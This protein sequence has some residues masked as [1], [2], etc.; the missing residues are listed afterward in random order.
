MAKYGFDLYP[1]VDPAKNKIWINY[2]RTQV[3]I[4]K[5]G[6][7]LCPDTSQN[8]KIRQLCL[9]DKCVLYGTYFVNFYSCN[10]YRVLCSYITSWF[11]RGVVAVGI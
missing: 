11:G 6:L 5:Y 10:K 7:D 4:A 2:V 1:F 8:R 9:M 3:K